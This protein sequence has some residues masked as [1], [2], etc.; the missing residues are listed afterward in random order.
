MSSNAATEAREEKDKGVKF[1]SLNRE[2]PWTYKRLK[3][4]RPERRDKTK[5]VKRGY[6]FS[7]T[8]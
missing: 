5:R 8:L 2:T 1:V 3:E 6:L 7:L 4:G